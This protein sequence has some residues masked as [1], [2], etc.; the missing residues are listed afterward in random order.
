MSPVDGA[1]SKSGIPKKWQSFFSEVWLEHKPYRQESHPHVQPLKKPTNHPMG[2][3]CGLCV[4]VAQTAPFWETKLKLSSL[5]EGLATILRKRSVQPSSC[6]SRGPKKGK[7]GATIL[8]PAVLPQ[9]KGEG[10]P[11]GL[12]NSQGLDS[13]NLPIEFDEVGRVGR[14]LYKRDCNPLQ[15]AHCR[16]RPLKP[17]AYE[18]HEMCVPAEPGKQLGDQKSRDPL[19][20]SAVPLTVEQNGH[21]HTMVCILNAHG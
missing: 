13:A 21:Q 2:V 11:R 18:L 9:R 20:N 5:A 15:K 12:A 1:G 17:A 19:N 14:V 10:S 16:N 4:C 7:N 3:L 8:D 6:R